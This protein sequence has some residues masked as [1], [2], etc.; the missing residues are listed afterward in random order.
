MRHRRRDSRNHET[1]G[2]SCCTTSSMTRPP[3]F[4]DTLRATLTVSGLT[5]AA[6]A[7]RSKVSPASLSRYLS[8]QTNPSRAAVDALDAALG[9][10]GALLAAWTERVTDDLPPFLRDV[11]TLESEATRIDLV[12]PSLVPGL[13]WS[14]SYAALAYESGRRVQDVEALA[15][16]RSERLGEI[17]ATV[18][19][20]FPVSALEGVPDDIRA[21]QVS[22]LLSLPPR[23]SVHLLPPRTLLLG[24]PGP[25]QV[26][27][28]REGR[29]VVVGDHLEGNHVYG[30][31][32]L[33]RARELVRDALSVSLPHVISMNELRGT[34]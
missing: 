9:A 34:T 17:T 15:R 3:S 23:V 2:G 10:S 7:A 12:S 24:I 32:A 5:Q 30:D 11:D 18:S 4:P 16:R 21:E 19:A 27:K 13:L 8:G 1:P 25:F 20:V 26:F 33:P 22:H 14:P 31:A 28:L 29:E 6:L